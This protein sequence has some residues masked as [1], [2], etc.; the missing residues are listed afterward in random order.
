MLDVQAAWLGMLSLRGK[1][2]STAVS[3]DADKGRGG[4]ADR[5][6]IPRPGHTEG[7]ICLYFPAEQKL[8]A[9]DTLFAGKHLLNP[10][11]RAVRLTR[12]FDLCTKRFWPCL[13]RRSSCPATVR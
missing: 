5:H 3:A 4:A 11:S 12:L 9:G 1:S 10:I 8:I 6:V 7:S 2:R 13:M